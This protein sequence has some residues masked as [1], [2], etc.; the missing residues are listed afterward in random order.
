MKRSWTRA[1]GFS[2]AWTIA[3]SRLS[4]C[5]TWRASW[6]QVVVATVVVG[7]GPGSCRFSAER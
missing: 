4:A 2:T 1:T 7:E 6:L 5:M 3:A